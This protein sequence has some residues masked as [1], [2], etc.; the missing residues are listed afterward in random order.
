MDTS[1]ETESSA[2]PES[3]GPSSFPDK[4]LKLVLPLIETHKDRN[5]VSL[6]CKDCYNSERLSRSRLFIGNCYSVSPEIVVRRFP[7]I[8]SVT[9]KGKPRF[10]DFNLVPEGWG[11]DVHAWLVM[12]ASKYP[13]LE[14]LR[15][16]R[17][18]I[19]DESLEFLAFNF[20]DFKKLSLSSCDGFSTDGLAAI[21]T[22]CKNLI[23]LDIQE[24]IIDDRS[25]DWLSCFPENLTSLEV[26]NFANLNREVDFDALQRLVGRCKSLK[27][28]KVNGSISLEQLEELLVCAPQLTELGTG[29]FSQEITVQYTDIETAFGNC[30]NLHSLSGLWEATALNLP[31][32]FPACANLTFLNLSYAALQGGDIAE[33]LAQCPHLRRLWVLDTVEDEGLEAVGSSCPLLEELRVF[34]ADPFDDKAIHGVTEAGFIAVSYGCPRLHYVLYFCRQMTNAAVA[35]VV[36]NCPDF[37]HFRL[38]IIAPGQPDYITNEP[39]DEAF[40]AVVKTCPKLRRLS[41]SGLLTDLAFEYIG[42]YAKNLEI[43]S[44]AFAGSSDWG[45]QC[46]LGGCPKL[47]KL[48]IR[49][50]PFGDAALLSGVE[51][52]ESMRSLWMSSCNVTMDGC[53]KLAREMPRLNVEVIKEDERDEGLAD[54]VYIYRSVAGPRRDAPPFVLTL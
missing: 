36:K 31:V 33:L 28:L 9:L 41:V 32:M 48:E 20:P 38:C 7:N 15:L 30:E 19:S 26:L 44:V 2:S 12:F 37:T 22:D 53:R 4:V 21:A 5:S 45:M 18:V 10:S 51:M 40:G 43:L 13:F 50:C 16:K 27:V 39:M 8:R 49:D 54:K 3:T 17:M 52:Y 35:T 42:K 14:E 34:P 1:R 24:N 47:R 46:V 23:E 11:A 6:V 25:G 29:S